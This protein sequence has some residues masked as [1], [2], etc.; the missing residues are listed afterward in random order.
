[1]F[2]DRHERKTPFVCL[3]NT[4]FSHCSRSPH[5]LISMPQNVLLMEIHNMQLGVGGGGCY[6]G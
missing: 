1:M 6:G 5:D 2:Q 4:F 3:T